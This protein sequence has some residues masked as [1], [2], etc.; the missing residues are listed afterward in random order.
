MDSLDD[1]VD[2]FLNELREVEATLDDSFGLGR[3]HA[4]LEPLDRDTRCRGSLTPLDA[5]PFLSTGSN[6]HVFTILTDFGANTNL[7]DAPVVLDC[8]TNEPPL[9][10]ITYGP[11]QFIRMLA[12]CWTTEAFE[13]TNMGP[14]EAAWIRDLHETW[15]DDAEWHAAAMRTA[16]ALFARFGELEGGVLERMSAARRRRQSELAISTIDGLG[17][18]KNPRSDP[19]ATRR[20]EFA[21]DAPDDAFAAFLRDASHDERLAACRDAQFMHTFAASYDA[22]V[23]LLV[24]DTLD[25]MGYT[26]EAGRARLLAES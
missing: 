14:D 24:A 10:L 26:V 6:A 4:C 16:R 2:S 20:F 15:F 17:I 19:S 3:L 18:A 25:E 11:R 22:D 13:D 8:H 7:D 21:S 9:R 5:I 23:A 12:T 1:Q